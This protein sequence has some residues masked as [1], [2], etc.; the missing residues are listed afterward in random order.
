[1]AQTKI[2]QETLAQTNFQLLD[3]WMKQG[4]NQERPRIGHYLG[5]PVQEGVFRF[6]HNTI[7]PK[8]IIGISFQVSRYGEI[9]PI[10]VFFDGRMREFTQ[11]PLRTI[12]ILRDLTIG[13]KIYNYQIDV[14]I[15]PG[16]IPLQDDILR[17]VDTLLTVLNQ[18]SE[19]FVAAYAEIEGLEGWS[20]LDDLR[21]PPASGR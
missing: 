13:Q 6:T 8:I 12:A 2:L 21:L 7:S 18:A 10:M 5:Y 17:D 16:I 1:M 3:W 14:G 4:L 15:L 9:Y 20:L 19:E 11:Y